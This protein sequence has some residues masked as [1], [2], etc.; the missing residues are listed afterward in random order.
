MNSETKGRSST[1]EAV[2]RPAAGRTC[3]RN[4]AR[5]AVRCA[6]AVLAVARLARM[7]E[8]EWYARG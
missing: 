1:A 8:P 2:H 5:L 6:V 4:R 7:S 3:R